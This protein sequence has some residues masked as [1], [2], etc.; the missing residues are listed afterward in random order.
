ML[1]F[2]TSSSNAAQSVASG[3][4]LIQ[5]YATTVQSQP[6]LSDL[7]KLGIPAEQFLDEAREHLKVWLQPDEPTKAL[8]AQMEELINN[9]LQWNDSFQAYWNGQGGFTA[10]IKILLSPGSTQAS[11]DTALASI[12]GKLAQLQSQI[13][14]YYNTADTLTNLFT[15]FEKNIATDHHNFDKAVDDFAKQN[16]DKS[17]K[18]NELKAQIS[19]VNAKVHQD[20]AIISVSTVTLVGTAAAMGYC[21]YVDMEFSEGLAPV[22]L[23][24]GLG[25]VGTSLFE[26]VERSGEL[27]DLQ[28]QKGDLQAEYNNVETAVVAASH[29]ASNIKALAT[30]AN[31]AKIGCNQVAINWS[32]LMGDLKNVIKDCEQGYSKAQRVI[33]WLNLAK[34]D[35]AKVS[36]DCR[37]LKDLGLKVTGIQNGKSTMSMLEMISAIEN[38]QKENISDAV[39]TSTLTYPE[40][41]QGS[42]K[43]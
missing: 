19:S 25:V 9:I 24:A 13:Q 38:Q 43:V 26:I 29:L 17:S 14:D 15:D 11:K 36:G 37:A 21:A 32:A 33:A 42:L 8:K 2:A 4:V 18:L 1:S 6:N 7:S 27:H 22:L 31:Q 5:A 35:W 3:A 40:L 34:S 23:A 28:I 41:F 12:A 10:N 39:L 20:I 30:A 16:A